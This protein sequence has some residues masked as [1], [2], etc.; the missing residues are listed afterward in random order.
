VTSLGSIC[1]LPQFIDASQNSQKRA[2]LVLER[3]FLHSSAGL[4]A[5]LR[6]ITF[7]LAEGGPRSRG[8]F[9]GIIGWPE[10]IHAVLTESPVSDAIRTNHD[11]PD[12]HSFES[13]QVKA[14]H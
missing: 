6:A 7:V 5:H 14:F 4:F 9:R 10:A 12:S 13:G 8:D 3:M 1:G 2:A 11:G